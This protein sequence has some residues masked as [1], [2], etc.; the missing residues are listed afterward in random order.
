MLE[1]AK[2]LDD[3]LAVTEAH[4]RMLIE[5]EMAFTAA[6]GETEVNIG[7][8]KGTW[9]VVKREGDVTV[10]SFELD[11]TLES[12]CS[13]PLLQGLVDT[14]TDDSPIRETVLC[15]SRPSHVIWRT[16]ELWAG[17]R[18][19]VPRIVVRKSCRNSVAEVD[20]TFS[21]SS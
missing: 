5:R 21:F 3:Q 6:F 8:R 17:A 16:L 9:T 14:L 10:D 12:R 19:H 15:R 20:G 11:D 2:E 1:Y 13:T 18:K 7:F 4:V